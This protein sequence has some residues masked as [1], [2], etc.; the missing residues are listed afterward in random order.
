[1]SYQ[2]QA[3]S[4]PVRKISHSGRRALLR[5]QPVQL[6]GQLLAVGAKGVFAVKRR[7]FVHAQH[8]GGVGPG[9]EILQNG[10][11]LVHLQ[12]A[13]DPGLV[14]QPE[15]LAQKRRAVLRVGLG[16]QVEVAFA[17][18]GGRRGLVDGPA[19]P[20]GQP[21]GQ[22]HGQNGRH[23][24]RQQHGVRRRGRAVQHAA[25]QQPR[26]GRRRSGQT[27]CRTHPPAPSAGRRPSAPRPAPR[28]SPGTPPT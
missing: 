5:A 27:A 19:H 6:L 12:K 15:I 25:G 4:S 2:Q 8:G 28:R 1:M 14:L 9:R 3:S 26:A 24:P 22:P 18:R 20:R 7:V 10:D 16:Q 21:R 23:K 13:V 17:R 11:A